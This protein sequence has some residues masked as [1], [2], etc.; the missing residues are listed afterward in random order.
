VLAFFKKV[1]R[2]VAQAIAS[3]HTVETATTAVNKV[4]DARKRLD[5]H[6]GQIGEAIDLAQ[7][8]RVA[9]IAAIHQDI[10]AFYEIKKLLGK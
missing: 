5:A 2:G 9:T 1:V 10:A 3:G 4:I 8:A 7:S 6:A